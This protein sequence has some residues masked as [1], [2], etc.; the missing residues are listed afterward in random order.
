MNKQ[1]KLYYLSIIRQNDC[2]TQFKHGPSIFASF[3]QNYL[4][5]SKKEKNG[6]SRFLKSYKTL[7]F[8][9]IWDFRLLFKTW[10]K[11]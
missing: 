4:E 6:Q 1:N 9:F 3:G 2:F 8:L 11:K 5:F 7:F 10:A